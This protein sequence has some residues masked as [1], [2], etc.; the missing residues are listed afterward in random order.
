MNGENTVILCPGQGAQSI[1]MGKAWFDASP[2]A[3]RTFGAADEIIGDRFGA[4]LSTL[5][6]E[7]PGDLLNRTDVAQP[8]LF[9]AG[10]ASFQAL[11]GGTDPT[12]L[13]A[14]AGLSLGE[15]TALHLA[16]AISFADCLELVLLRGRAMQD[17]ADASDGSMVALIGADP[18]QADE[19]CELAR[20]GGVLVPANF[21]APGQIVLSGS[22]DACGRAV[23]AASGVGVRATAL[24]VAGAFH[25]PL[26]EP[27]AD[28]LGEALGNTQIDA[29]RCLVLSNV[30]GE[31]HKPGEVQDIAA[32]I[33][34]RLVEQLV[35]PV[36]WSQGCEW[37][38]RHCDGAFH[39]LA[40]GKV[41]GGLMRRIDRS[42]KV[43]NHDQP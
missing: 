5:C 35:R 41:L 13:G 40:P 23:E 27:A 43:V 8:A 38:S 10:V 19:V 11:L 12:K 7:G 33:R 36:L 18:S 21:N 29:P 32:S 22:A 20:G 30:T 3:A 42:I 15:Y 26:M 39:E 17:A 2:D 28:R 9:T 37:L 34:T 4:K 25:S 1:E 24:S 6:F 16:G 31:P 14:I